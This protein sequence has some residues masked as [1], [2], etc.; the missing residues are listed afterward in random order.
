MV[1]REGCNLFLFIVAMGNELDAEAK[2]RAGGKATEKKGIGKAKVG[3]YCDVRLQ[4]G[5]SGI[6]RLAK[7]LL[8]KH[9][10]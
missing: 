6:L 7:D 9:V 1:S 5:E 10:G 2:S 8:H 4:N 3:W